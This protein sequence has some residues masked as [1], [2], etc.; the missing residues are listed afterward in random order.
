MSSPAL[1]L[2]FLQRYPATAAEVIQ[3]LDLGVAAAYLNTVSSRVTAPVIN[4][5]IPYVAAQCLG[6]LAPDRGA[7]VLR[8]L[9]AH[10]RTSLLRMLAPSE[11]AAMLD[12][13]PDR[14]RKRIL[15]A[16]AYPS[17]SIG[18]WIDSDVPVL[19]TDS[20]VDAARKYL[21]KDRALSHVFLESAKD[22]TYVGAVRLAD[23]IQAQGTAQLDE[24][25]ITRIRPLSNR[26]SLASVQFH[27]AW[28]EFLILPVL[29][30][31]RVLLGGL[32]RSAVRRGMHEQHVTLQHNSV[33]R[34]LINSLLATSTG[35]LKLALQP[36]Q[37]VTRLGAEDSHEH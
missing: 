22:G 18:A 31:G 15:S 11:R 32:T 5:L 29:G 27:A 13:L 24:L 20:R 23:L 19:R 2:A 10:E 7:A 33:A 37:S 1:T 3:E 17:S 21:T 6:R 35:L 12:E 25:P 30:G 34:E 9:A 4:H 36:K 16:L 14:M 28:D 26:A 8:R